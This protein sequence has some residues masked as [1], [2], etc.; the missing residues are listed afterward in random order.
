MRQMQN[1]F[2]QSIQMQEMLITAK[3]Q[4]TIIKSVSEDPQP[5]SISETP[6]EPVIETQP[7]PIVEEVK[8][9]EEL[10]T[11]TTTTQTSR[12]PNLGK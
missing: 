6:V 1:N 5:E 7:E 9:I 10:K 8:S 3:N 2:R 12:L 11:T 4:S